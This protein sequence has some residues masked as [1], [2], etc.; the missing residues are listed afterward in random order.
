MSGGGVINPDNILIPNADPDAIEAVGRAL[1]DDA[2]DI[3][4]AG[5]DITAAWAGLEGHYDA[6]ESE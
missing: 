5:H 3:A 2:A 1:K 6:P 4:Q